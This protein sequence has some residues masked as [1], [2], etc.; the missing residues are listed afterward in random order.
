METQVGSICPKCKSAVPADAY[1]CP[2]CGNQLKAKPSDTILL[3]KIYVYC[4]S[5]FLPPFGLWYAWKYFKYGDYESRKIGWISVILTIIS[6]I[7][8]LWLTAGF[9]NSVYQSLNEINNL[10]V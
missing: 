1:F 4:V 3:K 6:V 8:T 10:G 5:L 9:I 7:I 2:N